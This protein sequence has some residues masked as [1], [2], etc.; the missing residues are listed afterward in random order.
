MNNEDVME[1]LRIADDDLYSAHV[2]NESTH[3]P[4][5]VICYLCAQSAEKYLKGFLIYNDILPQ[6]THNLPYLNNMCIEKNNV[7]EN[8]KTECE[9]L[10]R[11]SNDIRYSHQTEIFEEDINFSIGAVEKI[12]NLNPLDKLRNKIINAHD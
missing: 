9:F 3:K 12:K 8:I 5:E 4:L 6:K 10:N 7:F 11:F 2:L 1:W